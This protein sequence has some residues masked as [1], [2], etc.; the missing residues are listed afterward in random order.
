MWGLLSC[1]DATLVPHQNGW[2]HSQYLRG[3]PRAYRLRARK[4]ALILRT[5]RRCAVVP[6]Y[7]NRSP[8]RD[9][10]DSSGARIRRKIQQNLAAV[11]YQRTL[12]ASFATVAPSREQAPHVG[13]GLSNL[14]NTCFVN[15]I[16]Q[17]LVSAP[18]F[19]RSIMN[20]PHAPRCSWEKYSTAT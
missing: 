5:M 10:T 7:P 11:E 15:A 6:H 20:A 4:A 18:A 8:G 17:A 3:S 9:G 14:G 19:V 1:P 16:L 13:C 2:S 12:L